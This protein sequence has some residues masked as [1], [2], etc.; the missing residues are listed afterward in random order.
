MG[1][2]RA[3]TVFRDSVNKQI[4]DFHN[5]DAMRYAGLK[6]RLKMDE[7]FDTRIYEDRPFLT[8]EEKDAVRSII[9]RAATDSLKEN[10]DIGL[11]GEKMS[12]AIRLEFVTE[13]KENIDTL[14][15]QDESALSLGQ[16]KFGL[17][18]DRGLNIS[19]EVGN[20]EILKEV[21]SKD[22][23]LYYD[24]RITPKTTLRLIAENKKGSWDGRFSVG[25][26]K[27][28]S[29]ALDI[30]VYSSFDDDKNFIGFGFNY[31]TD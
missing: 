20:M 29:P 14:Y 9:T 5:P 19:Y 7:L 8:E 23:A 30:G 10:E 4:S 1:F 6:T 25:V 11:L 2:N 28:I 16:S 13:E 24:K 31:I 17:K 27:N 22:W 21:G 18:F 12:R 26:Y 3:E 15:P